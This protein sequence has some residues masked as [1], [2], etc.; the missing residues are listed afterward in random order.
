VNGE[1]L[2]SIAADADGVVEC[3]TG[4][5]S[6]FPLTN[7]FTGAPTYRI[8]ASI[9]SGSKVLSHEHYYPSPEMHAAAADALAAV[10]APL[11]RT[12][13]AALPG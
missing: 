2:R 12:R 13:A 3:V 11:A 9:D 4:V 8:S 10:C 1:M 6:P 7:R 5:G